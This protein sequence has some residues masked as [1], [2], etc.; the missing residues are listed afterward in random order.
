MST[1]LTQTVV[2]GGVGTVVET[3]YFTLPVLPD[4]IGVVLTPANLRRID[5]SALD[6]ATSRRSIIEYI[7]T[8]WASDFNDFIASNGMVMLSE[9]VA[10]QTG[11]L[12][13]RSDLLA[14]ENFMPT[15]TTEAALT[16]HLALI[17][18]Q[19][20]PASPAI[21]DVQ[22]TVQSPLTVNIEIDPG[23]QFS[24]QGPDG[25]PVYYEVYRAPGDFDSKLVIP[26]GKRGIVG[27]GLEGR[28]V[29]PVKTT[30][31]GG[32]SQ[33]FTISANNILQ[34]PIT[35]TVYTGS[36]SADWIV[37]TD[38]LEKYGPTDTVVNVAIT[39]TT[40]TLTWGDDING[41]APLAGQEI[42]I[43]Y[44]V[45]GGIRGRIGSSAINESVPIAPLPPANAPVQVLFTN[46]T[47][48]SGGTDRETLAQ[49]KQRAPRDFVVRAFASDRPASIVTDGDYA[50]IAATFAHPVFGSVAKGIAVIRTDLNANLVE[51]Y[52]L[53]Y[54]PDSLVT[55]S[56]GLKL[57]LETYLDNFNVLTDTVSVLDGAIQPVTTDMTIVVNR[58]ADVSYVRTAVNNALDAFYDITTWQFGQPLYTSQLISAV[59]AVDGV[60]YADLFS[61]VNNILQT[62]KL[63]GLD[64]GVGVNEIIVETERNIRFYYESGSA[65]G[66]SS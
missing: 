56:A 48:S 55:P 16:E 9:I 6:F 51:V 2:S 30:S 60:L 36:A 5:F 13:L 65:A 27:Y 32:A 62:G 21:V 24:L 54:G 14:N 3:D 64:V 63:S 42:D 37:T 53:A 44:R 11:K 47:P 26:A 61:P 23:T 39:S 19:I 28:T 35:V 66:V 20:N 57:A 34:S 58:N 31:P 50:E 38:P 1:G 4:Q 40:M 12:S 8:Y 29:G 46:V 41:A 59:T 45:G 25:Q 10:A 43:T 52:I 33:T 18:Q 7:M 17:A 49:A 22:I 15:C